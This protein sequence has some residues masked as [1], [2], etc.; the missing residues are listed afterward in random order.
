LKERA[1][2]IAGLVAATLVSFLFA[3]WADLHALSR[4]Q[5]ELV[6]AL[7]L[8]SQAVLGEEL[9]DPAAVAESLERAKSKEEPDPMP[10][11]D[12]FDVIV[13]LSNAIPMAVTHDIEEFSLD[14]AHVKVNGIVPTTADAQNLAG[15]IGKNRCVSDSKIAKVSQVVN[16]N[17]QKYVLEFD[18]KC[19]EDA[20]LKKKPKATQAPVEDKP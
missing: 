1:P 8:Q 2:L 13:E 10:H 20:G 12:A 16:D 4:E 19:P 17:R 7:A 15:E 14:R 11:M 9:T 6:Q 5:Q 18:V 3:S